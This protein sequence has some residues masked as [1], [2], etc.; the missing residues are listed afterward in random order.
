MEA[1][2]KTDGFRLGPIE[3]S[4]GGARRQSQPNHDRRG[5]ASS[6]RTPLFLPRSRASSDRFF[7]GATGFAEG[8]S[9]SSSAGA[10]SG[11][12]FTEAAAAPSQSVAGA[13]SST[14]RGASSAAASRALSATASASRRSAAASAT[15]AAS[16]WRAACAAID[17]SVRSGT[18]PRPGFRQDVPRNARV[19]RFCCRAARGFGQIGLF[20]LGLGLGRLRGE[21]T[22]FADQPPRGARE[23]PRS[24]PDSLAAHENHLEGTV[25]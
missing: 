20:G 25:S 24:S 10:G 14:E 11:V 4:A 1:A 17:R 2:A 6:A 8:A 16:A 3:T 5:A 12:A 18:R 15:R 9:S 21:P 19:G 13:A 23:S 22:V 7:F